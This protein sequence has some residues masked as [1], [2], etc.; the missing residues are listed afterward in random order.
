MHLTSSLADA[1]DIKGTY[2]SRSG[3]VCFEITLDSHVALDYKRGVA[4]VL[5]PDLIT[6][7]TILCVTEKL[8]GA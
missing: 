5:F 7:G 2:E 4:I 6:D 3:G 1:M 8:H